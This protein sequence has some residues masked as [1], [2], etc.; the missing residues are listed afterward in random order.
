[1]V[2]IAELLQTYMMFNMNGCSPREN[3]Y[4]MRFLNFLKNKKEKNMEKINI[5]YLRNKEDIYRYSV[6]KYCLRKSFKNERIIEKYICYIAV[7]Q[8]CIFLL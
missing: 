4:R 8:F 7:V 2:D 3:V 1:M 6:T 5:T